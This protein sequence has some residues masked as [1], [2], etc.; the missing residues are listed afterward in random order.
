MMKRAEEGGEWERGSW[1]EHRRVVMRTV[2][3]ADGKVCIHVLRHKAARAA[4]AAAAWAIVCGKSP[5]RIPLLELL[6]PRGADSHSGSGHAMPSS[7]ACL[8]HG[9]LG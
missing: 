1:E 9:E 3:V 5:L 2:L 4:G 7:H 8:C 6:I